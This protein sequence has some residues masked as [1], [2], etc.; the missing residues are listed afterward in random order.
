MVQCGMDGSYTTWAAR[1]IHAGCENVMSYL[2]TELARVRISL[3][4]CK[5]G[6]KGRVHFLSSHSSHHTTAFELSLLLL[7]GS[8]DM[9][10]FTPLYNF[11]ELQLDALLTKKVWAFLSLQSIELGCH[12]NQ[13][14]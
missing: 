14:V 10:L 4:S 3:K 6:E 1:Y 13:G 11:T 9:I 5:L 8:C 7:E 12:G 2:Q